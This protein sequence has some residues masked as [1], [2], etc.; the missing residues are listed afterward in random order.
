SRWS[1]ERCLAVRSQCRRA[2]DS[3]AEESPDRVPAFDRPFG[4]RLSARPAISCRCDRENSRNSAVITDSS[5]EREGFEPSVP[6]ELERGGGG[7]RTLISHTAEH[8]VV[9]ASQCGLT[10]K[11]AASRFCGEN[12]EGRSS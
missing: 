11:R 5:L 2:P 6:L 10:G 4:E 9:S 3:G 1:E 7:R 8:Q 12:P